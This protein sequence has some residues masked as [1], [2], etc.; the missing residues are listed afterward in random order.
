MDGLFAWLLA[1]IQNGV[2]RKIREKED[3]IPLR[4]TSKRHASD[5]R[6]CERRIVCCMVPT[7][8]PSQRRLDGKA[9]GVPSLECNTM[10]RNAMWQP[11]S[12]YS[13]T[14]TGLPSSISQ[15]I[16]YV[17]LSLRLWLW[18]LSL[19]STERSKSTA[20]HALIKPLGLPVRSATSIESHPP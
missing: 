14:P 19:H 16:C 5:S 2:K 8:R 1:A 20:P 9:S 13:L 7:W 15:P 3:T 17:Q 10:Q 11:I 18:L 4:K 12:P 6:T